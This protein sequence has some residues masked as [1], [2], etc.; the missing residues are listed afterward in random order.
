M[1]FG[2]TPRTRSSKPGPY[3]TGVPPNRDT[4]SKL[5]SLAVPTAVGTQQRRL[6]QN[7]HADG[8]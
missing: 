8:T 3:A 1:P 7:A 4:A 6:L 2:A 5:I